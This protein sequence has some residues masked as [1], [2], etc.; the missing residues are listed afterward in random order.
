MKFSK[1]SD[2]KIKQ[3]IFIGPQIRYIM[4]D[5]H[6]ESLLNETELAAWHFIHVVKNILGTRVSDKSIHLVERMADSFRKM[7]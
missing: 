7:S 5:L 1:L 4:D 2:A 3:G 6:F